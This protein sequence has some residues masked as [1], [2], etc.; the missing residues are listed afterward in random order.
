MKRNKLLKQQNSK[1]L[2]EMVNVLYL[3]MPVL[4]ILSYVGVALTTYATF[5]TKYFPWLIFPYYIAAILL[6]S[7]S[8]LFLFWK[9]V[10]LS[11]FNNPINQNVVKIMRKMGIKDEDS[12]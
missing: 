3:T 5:V 6:V 2:G 7:V 10:Y 9:F 1:K 4:G 8:A 12:K 11:F